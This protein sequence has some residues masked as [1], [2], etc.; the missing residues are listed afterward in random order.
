[1]PDYSRRRLSIYRMDARRIL[2]IC[3]EMVK[4]YLCIMKKRIDRIK[5]GVRYCG[6]GQDGRCE[7]ANNRTERNAKSYG[8]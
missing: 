3:M 5:P 7:L 8:D 6:D 2:I 1:M 4:R